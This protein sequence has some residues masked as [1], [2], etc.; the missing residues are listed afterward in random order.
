MLKLMKQY[1]IDPAALIHAMQNHDELTMELIHFVAHKDD[2]FSFHGAQ[3][4]GGQL[5]SKVHEEMFGKLIGPRAPYNLK[6]GDGVACTTA[7]LIAATLGYSDFAKVTKVDPRKIAQLHLLLA[8]YNAMQPGVFALSGWDLVGAMTLPSATVKDRLAD[9]DT[10][11]INRGA[12]DLLGANRSAMQS[13]AGLPKAF[14]IY[15]SLPE[16]LKHA[17]SFASQLARMLQVRKQLQLYAARQVD[18]PEVKAKGLLAMVHELPGGGGIEITALNFGATPVD[19]TISLAQ[20]HAGANV[21]D[22]LQ[23]NAPQGAVSNGG[24]RIQLKPYEF[25]A[26]VVR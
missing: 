11:W 6:A 15:G 24:V 22:A 2:A 17:D 12:Y 9:G 18:V 4:S 5:R 26:L 7:S 10:R 8:A 16:Q 3:I 21:V 14:S 23:S 20:A 19:E 13:S 1:Q 25:K